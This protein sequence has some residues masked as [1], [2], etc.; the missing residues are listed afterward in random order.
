MKFRAKN[1]LDNQNKVQQIMIYLTSL[2]SSK[3]DR[4]DQNNK[5]PNIQILK[6]KRR[7]CFGNYE[8]LAYYSCLK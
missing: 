2:L 8:A 5:F 7:A 3:H 6:E 1:S 4:E